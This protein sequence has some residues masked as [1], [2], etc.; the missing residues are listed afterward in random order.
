MK[1]KY[2]TLILFSHLVK[3]GQKRQSEDSPESETPA[4]KEKV[5]EFNGTV[6]KAMLKEAT[7]AKKGEW[8]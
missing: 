8:M 6:F 4:K 3:M 5:P 7:T 1:I 2:K